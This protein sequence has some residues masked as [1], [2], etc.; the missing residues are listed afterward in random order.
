MTALKKAKPIFTLAYGYDE[1]GNKTQKEET[2]KLDK[3]SN[4]S[5]FTYNKRN[6]LIQEKTIFPDN[7]LVNYTEKHQFDKA[8]NRIAYKRH[9]PKGYQNVNKQQTY[10]KTSHQ[11]E[12][13]QYKNKQSKSTHQY[14]K[15]GNKTETI[16]ENANHIISKQ[17]LT[18][19]T[20]ND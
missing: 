1:A 7:G 16:K 6:E 5:T 15:N 18:W 19:D 20:Q 8:G 17:T 2:S 3:K 10:S 11:L 12:T 4:Q 14:D 9:Y 13:T